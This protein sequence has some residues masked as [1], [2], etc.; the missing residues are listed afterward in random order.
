MS[1]F[2]ESRKN[3]VDFLQSQNYVKG[4]SAAENRILMLTDVGDN[5]MTDATKFVEEVAH[6]QSIHTTIIGV[7]D[8]FISSTCEKMNEVSGFNY[9]CATEVEDLKKYL[10]ENFNFTF[11]PSNYNIQIDLIENKNVQSI[12]VYGTVDSKRVREY[13][14]NFVDLS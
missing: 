9:F 8:D 7:S 11:F 13:N 4:T 12:E 10:F 14:N 2:E 3:L 6:S 1:G 5:S